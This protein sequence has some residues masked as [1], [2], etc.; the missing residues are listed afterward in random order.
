MFL[1][2]EVYL[3]TSSTDYPPFDDS[4][5]NDITSG[6]GEIEFEFY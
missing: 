4:K 3:G 1:V 5:W 6:S 2:K